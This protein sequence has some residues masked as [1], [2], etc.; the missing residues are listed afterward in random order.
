MRKFFLSGTFILLLYTTLQAQITLTEVMYN[1]IGPEATDEFIEIYNTSATDTVN[2]RGYRVGDGSLQEPIISPDSLYYLLPGQF[3]VIFDLDYLSQSNSYDDLIPASAKILAVDDKTL[4]SGGL[5][6]SRSETVLVID[7]A[8]DTVSSYAY[9]PGNP[10]GISI[11]KIDL[12]GGDRADNWANSLFV[13]GTPGRNNS[14]TPKDF[15]LSL[16]PAASFLTPQQPRMGQPLD[17]NFVIRNRGRRDAPGGIFS[18]VLADT[19]NLW[20]ESLPTLSAGD[21]LFRSVRW[22]ATQADCV[23]IRAQVQFAADEQPGNNQFDGQITVSWPEQA[24]IINEIMFNPVSGAPEWVEVFNLLPMPVPLA[25]WQLRDASGQT[26][27]VEAERFPVLKPR[28]LAV[29]TAD[30]S[31]GNFYDL[32]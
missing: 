15:D 5:S 31:I 8:G 21:S 2:L 14:V 19:I 24:V 25:N 7:A 4:G 6:N 26:G 18:V 13:N 12:S 29:L 3:A 20:H 30:V 23:K 28:G 1:P 10:P 27:E 16:A 9:L 22:L 32:P 17:L 11:E